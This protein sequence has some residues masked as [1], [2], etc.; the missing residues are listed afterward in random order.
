MK[1]G[2]IRVDGPT[3]PL[4]L[5]YTE[6]S[7]RHVQ[8]GV[9]VEGLTREIRRKVSQAVGFSPSVDLIADQSMTEMG[10]MNTDLMGPP[11]L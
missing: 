9:C 11:R 1:V 6:W 4:T 3:G 10:E 8:A 2:T 5:G 7:E